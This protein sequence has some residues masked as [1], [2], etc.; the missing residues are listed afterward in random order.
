MP[1]STGLQFYYVVATPKVGEQHIET[2][3][4]KCNGFQGTNDLLNRENLKVAIAQLCHE[5]RVCNF[6]M[7][8]LTQK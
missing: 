8:W 7:L 4:S 6:T 1:W 5:L 3:F 2:K